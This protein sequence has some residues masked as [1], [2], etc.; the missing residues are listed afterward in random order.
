VSGNGFREVYKAETA[1]DG[2]FVSQ[3]H[4]VKKGSKQT[5]TIVFLV[6]ENS[7]RYLHTRAADPQLLIWQPGTGGGKVGPDGA[8]RLWK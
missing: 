2:S 5:G 8:I 6:P 3:N 4:S 1:A 7:L